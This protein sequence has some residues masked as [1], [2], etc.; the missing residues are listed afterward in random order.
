M[1]VQNGDYLI[2]SA[3]DTRKIVRSSNGNVLLDGKTNVESGVWTLEFVKSAQA[4]YVKNRATG[5]YLTIQNSAAAENSNIY[6]TTKIKNKKNKRTNA[7]SKQAK[8]QQWKITS[9]ANGYT[10]TSAANSSLYLTIYNGNA[11]LCKAGAGQQFFWIQSIYGQS[12][13]PGGTY[14][15]SIDNGALLSV[16]GMG[17]YDGCGYSVENNQ[18]LLS[19]VFD[20]QCVEAGYYKITNVN[21]GK[22]ITDIGGWAGQ[23]KYGYP[24][25][26]KKKK[27]KTTVYSGSNPYQ[28]WSARLVSGGKVQ[29]VNKATGQLLNVNG[30]TSWRMSPCVS[31]IN[32]VGKKAL[33]KANTR[34]S[35]TKY[36][37]VCDLTWHEVFIFEKVDRSSKSGPWKLIMNTRVSSGAPGTKTGSGDTTIRGKHYND[38][39]FNCFYWTDIKGTYFHSLL[40]A[41]NHTP[42]RVT[43]GRLGMYISHGCIRMK[44]QYAKWIFNSCGMGTAV[45]RYY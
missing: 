6:E 15:M 5:K 26:V 24:K 40:Y 17:T 2:A 31:G 38:P 32:E 10:L 18:G 14:T 25:V 9:S 1:V 19:Q 43:D 21:S 44:I 7:S 27:K 20:L 16:A 8:L 35:K 22:S 12:F 42:N 41:S 4:Y 39:R 28:L 33:W 37:I 11:A 13:L 36:C 29:F 45:S 34:T 23:K 3:Q 30:V